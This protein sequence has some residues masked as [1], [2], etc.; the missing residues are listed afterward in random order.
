MTKVYVSRT[1]GRITGLWAGKQ[2]GVS[3]EEIDDS[4][5]EVQDFLNP[6]R[7]PSIVG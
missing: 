3:L 5:Q 4:T 1:N 6:R 7:V 2:P